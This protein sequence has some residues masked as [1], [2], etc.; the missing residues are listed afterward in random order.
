MPFNNNKKRPHK[1]QF[2]R[3]EWDAATP[4][5]YILALNSLYD[6]FVNRYIGSQSVSSIN[7]FI[8]LSFCFWY[9]EIYMLAPCHGNYSWSLVYW[10]F[11][12]LKLDVGFLFH[13]IP[14]FQTKVLGEHEICMKYLSRLVQCYALIFCMTF[15]DVMLQKYF[16]LLCCFW[17]IFQ[18]F[19]SSKA[20]DSRNLAVYLWQK[21]QDWRVSINC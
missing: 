12:W 8:R 7:H 14:Y 1:N 18:L 21:L 15:S 5:F 9:I 17:C 2:H 20:D 6:K 16:F 4:T 19:M 3:L 11:L 10:R 13:R